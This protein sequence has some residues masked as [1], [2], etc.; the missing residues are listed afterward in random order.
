MK[1]IARLPAL[2]GFALAL[3][4]A[5]VQGAAPSA[6]A[7][8]QQRLQAALPALLAQ[9]RIASVSIAHIENR[10]LV[11]SIAQGEAGPGSA[12][13]PATLYNVA[14]LAKP[15]SAET[16]LRLAA[17]QNVDLD[18][19]MYTH[20]LDP[21]I[22]GDPR[23]RL[24][25]PRLSLSHRT[26]FPNWRDGKLAFQQQPGT[27]IGYS[28]EGFEYLARFVA[29]KTGTPLDQWA[30]QLVFGPAGMQETAYTRQPWFDGRLALPHDGDG[31]VL[32]LQIRTQALASDDVFSTPRDYARFLIALMQG[33]G[34]T[35]ALAAERARIQSDRR[36]DFCK[37]PRANDC[38]QEIG[39]GLGWESF[40]IDGRRYLLHTGKDEGTFTLAYFSPDSG[41]GTVIFTNS[42]NGAQAVLPVLDLIGQD[43]AFVALLRRMA[44]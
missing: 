17:R 6:G 12:A 15:L 35:P 22:A 18:E 1:R 31:K 5:A 2:A 33:Q 7:G 24:L 9:Q 28:G 42:N 19:P 40:L 3:F 20:W 8:P 21:D 39:F 23:A 16:V 11:F 4:A 27:R 14:S 10:R 36:A 37:P 41:N 13:T 26:G 25:T 44:G 29:N 30:Q 43:A 32:P 34:L 38:P